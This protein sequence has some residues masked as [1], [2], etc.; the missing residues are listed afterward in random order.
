MVGTFGV[1]IWKAVTVIVPVEY[2]GHLEKPTYTFPIDV[3]EIT[4]TISQNIC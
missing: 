3:A 2:L 1:L 4:S